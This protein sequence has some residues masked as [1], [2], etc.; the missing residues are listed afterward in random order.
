MCSFPIW[1]LGQDMEFV[2]APDHLLPF[3]LIWLGRVDR[4][5]F[6]TYK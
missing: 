2:S 4:V 5:G 6:F 3:H 1:C